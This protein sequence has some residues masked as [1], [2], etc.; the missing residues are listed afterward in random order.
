MPRDACEL[1]TDQVSAS[2]TIT[3]TTGIPGS[4]RVRS[5]ATTW[6]N[7]AAQNCR[8]RSGSASISAWP[9]VSLPLLPERDVKKA[10]VF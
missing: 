7:P 6:D 9:E 8:D 2:G 5:N 10:R 3:R 4:G 1:N